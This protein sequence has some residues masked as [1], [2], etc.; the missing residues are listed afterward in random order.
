MNIPPGLI[1]LG[2]GS[3]LCNITRIESS[4]ARFGDRFLDR[5]YTDI[6]RA[7]A[8]KRVM[9]RAA[10]Y[11]KRFAAKEACAKA[12]GTGLRRGVFWRDMGVVNL[13]SGAP[14]LALT[15]GA[16]ARLAELTPSGYS[17]VIHLTITDDHP[18][19]QA[20]VLITASPRNV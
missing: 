7:K 16:A 5:I 19:A 3:D 6:E 2:L 8:D 9:T 13:P 17:A 10:T 11:A 15:G 18:W 1:V 4:I 12:L 20:I 14:T